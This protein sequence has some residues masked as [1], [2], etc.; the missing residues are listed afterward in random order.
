MSR[1]GNEVEE[2]GFV[3]GPGEQRTGD[4]QGHGHRNG[5]LLVPFDE[6]VAVGGLELGKSA[7]NAYMYLLSFVKDVGE[8]ACPPAPDALRP[9]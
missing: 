2:K 1:A 9:G 6:A 3:A 5:S 4:E 8:R 7:I